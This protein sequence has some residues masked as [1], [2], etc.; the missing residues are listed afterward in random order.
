MGKLYDEL[1]EEIEFDHG[2]HACMDCGTCTALCAAAE[3]YDYS[4]REVMDIV[5][6][7]DDDK[8]RELISSNKIWYCGQCLSCKPRCPRGNNPGAVVLALRRLSVK[9]G[10]FAESEK[11]RQ[12]LLAK[13]LFGDNM[14]NRGYTLLPTNPV[15]SHFPELGKDW[16]Y[17]HNHLAEMR[18]WWGVPVDLEN[19]PGSARIIPEKD[20]E[21]LRAIYKA[22]GAVDLMNAVE[23]G[24]AKKLGGK[25]E[26]E[27]FWKNWQDTVDTRNYKIKGGK[28]K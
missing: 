6:S 15:P 14:M 5:Q 10:L 17:Y 25:E 7:Q 27:K 13:R 20:M 19:S 2:M 21:E 8:I 28:S 12:Q 1:T 24:M 26:V 11:G 18:E 4:P 9:T 16:E 23:D 3:F 22:T